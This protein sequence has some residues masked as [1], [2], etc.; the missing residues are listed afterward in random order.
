LS[1]LATNN[2][3]RLM[4]HLKQ[5]SKPGT[6]FALV[7]FGMAGMPFT[8][9]SAA[10]AKAPPGA[11]L[12]ADCAR[13]HGAKGEGLES[14]SAP[15]LAGREDWYMKSQLEKFRRRQRGQDDSKETGFLPPEARTQLM[16]PVADKLSNSDMKALFSYIGTLQPEPV[17]PPRKGSAERGQARYSV[18]ADCHGKS[19]EGARRHS[20]PRLTEQ[21]DWYL[22]NQ[23]RDFRMGWRG[24]TKKDEKDPHLKLMR[25]NLDLDDEA[26]QDLAAYIVSLNPRKPQPPAGK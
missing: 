17:P 11:G 25:S 10:D 20:A 23:L 6:W 4:N 18:C 19:A 14:E 22:F 2:T 3:L 16:H 24:A 21:H 26:L 13:C 7:A 15:R 9:A 5:L 1:A 12:F 8:E